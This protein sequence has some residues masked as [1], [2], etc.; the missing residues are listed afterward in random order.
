M[1][2]QTPRAP[3]GAEHAVLEE[4]IDQ[5]RGYVQR[6]RAITPADVDEMEDHLRGQVADLTASGLE[7]DEAFLVAVKRMGNLDEVSREFA[8]EHSGRLWKQL[9]LV[10]EEAGENGRWRE[11][12]VVLALAVAS[13]IW[14]KILLDAA[15]TDEL[16]LVR[17]AVF[18]VLPFLAGYFAWKRRVPW[19]VSAV[20]LAATAALA[21]VVN[22]YPFVEGPHGDPGMTG[23]LAISHTP[24]VLWL[25]LGVVYAGGAWRSGPRRMDFVRFTGEL[26]I[27]LALIALGGGLLIG[28]TFGTLSL[29]GVDFEPFLGEWLLPFAMPGA[30]LVGAW[31]VEAKKNVVENI[32]PVLTRVFTPLTIVMLVALFVALLVNGP[33]TAVDRELLILMDAILVLVLF[34]LLYSISARDPLAPAGIFDWLQLVLVGAALAVDAVALTAMLTRIAE[35]GFTANKV[36]A[37]GLNLVLLV[38][39]VWAAWLNLGFARGR[40]P[41]ADV[42]RWQTQYLPVYGLW[43]AIVV[44]AFGPIFAFA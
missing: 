21:L 10:P 15:G 17:N 40:R 23:F 2:E 13:G 32:A 22:L 29:V 25:L 27:Y 1:S 26:I 36:A 41:F 14:V 12:G 24:V 19:G 44:V 8:R 35:F 4:Q 42:E 11:L 7:D 20:L 28:L 37:L 39:L 43:A 31:L 3:Q 18:A 5:W 34:L 33:L 9:V 30:L 16:V 38:H 6:R